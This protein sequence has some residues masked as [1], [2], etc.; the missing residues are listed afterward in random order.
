MN[1]TETKIPTAK[2]CKLRPGVWGAA[3]DDWRDDVAA[4]DEI[5]IVS[6]RGKRWTTTVDRVVR[7]EYA[8]TDETGAQVFRS[9]VATP[10][11][12][13]AAPMTTRERKEARIERRQDW[14][15]GR[16]AKSEAA[17]NGARQL[18]DAIPFGQPILVGHHSE[19]RARRDQDRIHSGMRQ[20]VESQKMA[21]THESKA[22]GIADQLE[23]AI[24]SDDTEV[25]S[26]L[27]ERIGELEAQRGRRKAIN[28]WLRKHA[29]IP[30]KL[31]YSAT[32][33]ELERCKEPLIRCAKALEMTG[34][35]VADLV[36]AVS[37][38]G[39]L[40]YPPY[41]MTNLGANIRRNKKRLEAIKAD[42]GAA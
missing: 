10:P 21:E 1:A 3:L 19:K 9:V 22:A 38:G 2:P 15:V 32:A 20:G 7:R 33:E 35:E 13:G 42:E 25:I 17:Y 40:G 23:T 34:S 14:A 31:S 11:K 24:Y 30:T 41:A 28:A 6:R 26:R 5:E 4:G 39:R 16:R 36:S 27:E 12:D 18:A 8:G 29:G 37:F